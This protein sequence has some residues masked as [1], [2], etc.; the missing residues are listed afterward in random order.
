MTPKMGPAELAKATPLN[1]QRLA[2][3]LGLSIRR[4]RGMSLERF[5]Y[6]LASRVAHWI[7]VEKRFQKASR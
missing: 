1:L 3:S 7:D 5:H 2:R 6:D 4:P